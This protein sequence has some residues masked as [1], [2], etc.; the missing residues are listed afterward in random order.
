MK[1][2]EKNAFA[3]L[4]KVS[5]SGYTKTLSAEAMTLWWNILERYELAEIRDALFRYLDSKECAFP[6]QP[7]QISNIIRDMKPD[8]RPGPDEAWAM[9]PRDEYASVVMT[10]EMVEALQFAQ[11]LLDEGDQVAAWMA[12][13]EAYARIVEQNRRTGIAPKWFPSLGRDI[14]GREKALAEAVR[15]G[16]LTVN[17]AVGLLP[18]QNAAPMLEM[19]GETKLALE[20]RPNTELAKRNIAKLKQMLAGIGREVE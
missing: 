5:L 2:T 13:K 7:G 10:E 12:F 19:A 20:Y 1:S 14:A 9:I 17:H 18:P 8:G 3:A 4:L 16:R 15:M 6:P 11:P